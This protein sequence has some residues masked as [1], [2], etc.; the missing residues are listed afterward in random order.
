MALY[1]LLHANLFFLGKFYGNENVTIISQHLNLPKQHNKNAKIII[2]VNYEETLLCGF[3]RLNPTS[4]FQTNLTI[5]SSKY[6]WSPY[7]R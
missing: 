3:W 5:H 6:S 2:T 1:Q 4:L 7:S